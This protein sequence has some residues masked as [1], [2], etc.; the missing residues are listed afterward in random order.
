MDEQL[1]KVVF[2]LADALENVFKAETELK[3]LLFKLRGDNEKKETAQ[4]SN[5]QPDA[6]KVFG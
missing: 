6:E 3:N 5:N 2:S 4:I 1:K